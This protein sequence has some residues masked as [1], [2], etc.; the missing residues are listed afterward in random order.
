MTEK[1]HNIKGLKENRTKLRNSLT[2]AEA[3]LWSLLKNGQIE[4]RKFRRQHSVGPYVLDFYCPSERLCIEL[5]GAAHFTDGGNEYDTARTEYL[6]ALDIRVIRFENKD[7]FENTE[8]VLEEIRINC[9]LGQ[10]TPACGHP[11]LTK[12]GSLRPKSWRGKN[13]RSRQGGK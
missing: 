1:I 11:S 6:E 13:L 2:P 3:K 4:K 9:N 7:V 12:A 10:T 8:G 5:D